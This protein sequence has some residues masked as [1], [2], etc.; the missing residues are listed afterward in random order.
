M[1]SAT[2]LGSIGAAVRGDRAL[3]LISAAVAVGDRR[4]AVEELAGSRC[5]AA[6]AQDEAEALATLLT[7]RAVEYELERTRAPLS[8]RRRTSSCLRRPR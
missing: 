1:D 8:P 6:A 7:R 4:S 2:L 5:A 3:G